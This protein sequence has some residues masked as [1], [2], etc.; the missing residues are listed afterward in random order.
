MNDTNRV[1]Q[2]WPLLAVQDIQ[3]SITFYGDRLGF[4]LVGKAGSKTGTYWC[5][6]REND[7]CI[8]LQQADVNRRWPRGRARAGRR[9]LLHLAGCGPALTGRHLITLP[10]H[11][12][13]TAAE[14]AH[15]AARLTN[16]TDD[17]RPAC[18]RGVKILFAAPGGWC[19]VS[20]SGQ[21]II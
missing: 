20:F 14:Q 17:T 12:A 2:L 19:L 15:H 5:Q 9:Y 8:V 18:S 10:V 6:L 16:P 7:V 4:T 3:R 11:V 1:H 21:P 13:D